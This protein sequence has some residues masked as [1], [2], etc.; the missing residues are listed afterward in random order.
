MSWDFSTEP[1]LQEKLDCMR[2]FVPEEVIPLEVLDLTIAQWET[3][4][5][6]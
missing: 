4:S 3:S 6:R 1:E 5:A 2:R